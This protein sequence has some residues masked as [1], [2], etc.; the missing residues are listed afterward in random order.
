MPEYSESSLND[1]ADYTKEENYAVNNS[2]DTGR[3]KRKIKEIQLIMGWKGWRDNDSIT[4]EPLE[5]MIQDW[6]TE[7]RQYCEKNQEI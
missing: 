7:V 6:A 5:N 4:L 2:L 1:G 3:Y